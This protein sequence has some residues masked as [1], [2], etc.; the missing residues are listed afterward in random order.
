MLI[1]LYETNRVNETITVIIAQKGF[2]GNGLK[3][4]LN[5]Y[6]AEM[7]TSQTV[8]WID[9][10]VITGCCKLSPKQSMPIATG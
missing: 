9:K 4:S 2:V 5:W 7:P 3:V 8:A 1:G 10:Y 6:H